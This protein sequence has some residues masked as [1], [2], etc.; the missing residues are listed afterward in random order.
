MK[1]TGEIILANGVQLD[2]TDHPKVFC[3]SFIYSRMVP[4]HRIIPGD[5]ISLQEKA[6][7]C[8]RVVAVRIEEAFAEPAEVKP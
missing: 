8:H 7:T 6:D 1:H 4:S 5:Y 3:A 2:I